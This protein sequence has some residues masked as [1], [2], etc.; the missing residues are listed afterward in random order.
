MLTSNI[1][2]SINRGEAALEFHDGLGLSD[3][4][5]INMAETSR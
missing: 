2:N 5:E 4:N 1:S 3:G